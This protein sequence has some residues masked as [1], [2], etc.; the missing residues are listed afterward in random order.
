MFEDATSVEREAQLT[1]TR[2]GRRVL[3]RI[4]AVLGCMSF[5]LAYFDANQTC[6]G[7][8]VTTADTPGV[9][10][11]AFCTTMTF[12]GA[13]DTAISIA[14]VASLVA[15]LLGC[16]AATFRRKTKPPSA[17]IAG[18]VAVGVGVG[19]FVIEYLAADVYFVGAG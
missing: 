11:S 7:L 18:L 4:L 15:V 6:N 16:V 9:T 3:A 17:L 1:V 19:S 2:S 10:Q 8:G 13:P 12:P 14:L 5:V